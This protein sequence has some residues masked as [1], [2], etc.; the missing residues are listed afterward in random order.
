MKN[1]TVLFED[2]NFLVLNKP[3]GLAVQGGAGVGASLDSLLAGAYKK[4]PFLVHR[5]DKDTSGV[6]VT[7]KT[8]ESAAACSGLFASPAGL[9]KRYLAL[10][11][12]MPDEKGL[13]G[14]TLLVKGR[15]LTAETSYRRLAWAHIPADAVPVS[16]LELQPATGR[17]HQ[18]R[19]HLA[20]INCPVLGDDKYGDFTLNKKLR[21]SLGLKRLLLHAASIR[22]PPSL[23]KG[24]VEINA[25]LPDYFCAA[26]EKAG[27][28]AACQIPIA[29]ST[30]NRL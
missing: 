13:I 14:E 24:G 25:P 28:N 23:V 5:L 29:P 11:A 10:C 1:I 8:R 27:I 7:A 18:I 2:D 22:L 17:M 19:R 21:R 15:E 30:K 26:L 20:R 16:F 3:A 4:R 9:H 12:G 6:I